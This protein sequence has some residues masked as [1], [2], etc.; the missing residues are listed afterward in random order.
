MLPERP[1]H[2]PWPPA[3]RVVSRRITSQ[4][5]SWPWADETDATPSDRVRSPSRLKT[6]TVEVPACSTRA[7][8]RRASDADVSSS[9]SFAQLCI[10]P[11]T[12]HDRPIAVIYTPNKRHIQV[13]TP[14]TIP[15]EPCPPPS[16]AGAKVR[17]TRPAGPGYPRSFSFLRRHR[18]DREQS[19]GSEEG[20]GN[21]HGGKSEYDEAWWDA[22]SA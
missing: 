2:R 19:S 17:Y 11:A 5:R 8:R 4:S 22:A 14:S 9:A 12:P 7:G 10:L 16:R 15:R 1:P 18:L 20:G 13:Y 3:T 6:L 21:Q